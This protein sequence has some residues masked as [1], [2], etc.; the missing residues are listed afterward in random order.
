MQDQSLLAV[1]NLAPVDAGRGILEQETGV[2]EHAGEGRQHL[3][4]FFIEKAEV[5]RDA[6]LSAEAEAECVEDR[7]A[8]RVNVLARFERPSLQFLIIESSTRAYL[9][10]WCC[11]Q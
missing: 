5:G 4:I 1:Q 11:F 7:V 3:E 10:D 6:V 2:A 9:V 8:P